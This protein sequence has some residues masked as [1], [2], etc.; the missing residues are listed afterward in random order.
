[1]NLKCIIVE[2]EPLAIDVI[3][4]F[5]RQVPFLELVAIC[6]D[7][8]TAMHTLKSQPVDLMFL[9]LH[10][11]KLKGLDFLQT[12]KHPPMVII[13]TAY[14][15]YALKSY[16]YEVLDY[17]LKPVEFGRF[18]V[19]VQKALERSHVLP[20]ERPGSEPA[21][22]LYFI[23][24]KKKARV[25]LDSILYIESQK[26]NICI[27]TKEKT[28]V[29]KYQISDLEKELPAAQFIR[30]HRSFIVAKGKID[31]V[32]AH[33]IEIQGKEI[34]IGRSYRAFVFKRLGI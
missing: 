30:V 8:L 3:E 4:D 27:V 16:D 12:L 9:D 31:F 5:V 20:Q 15:E 24:N 21:T 14:Q 32:D 25:S 6:K 34:P 10:L 23:I 33:D 28:L 13:T 17:L 7:A 1:M 29:T 26:E 18:M 2:D 11:P 19:A 22:D